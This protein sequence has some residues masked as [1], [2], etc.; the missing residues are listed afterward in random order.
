MAKITLMHI[1]NFCSVF[2]LMSKRRPKN[3][4]DSNLKLFL[5]VIP[6]FEQYIV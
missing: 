6:F 4:N 1:M 2:A 3:R 5:A